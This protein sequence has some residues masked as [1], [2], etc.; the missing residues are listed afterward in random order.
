MCGT[1]GCGEHHHHHEHDHEHGH[2]HQHPHHHDER[3]VINLEQDILQRNNL[4]AERNR[5]YFEAKHIFCLNLMSSPGSGKTSLLEETVRRLKEKHPL[6]VVEGDQ[7]TSNDA[8]RIAAL[9]IPVFQVNTGTGC[10]LEADMVNH[11]VKHLAPV[12]NSILFIEN[13][14]NLVCPAMFNLGEAKKVVIVSTTEGDDKPLKYPH[15]FVEADVCIINKV[16]LAPYLDTDV[17]VLRKNI[18]NVNHHMQIFEVSATKG[19]G[20]EAWCNWLTDECTKCK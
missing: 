20:M 19:T 13:V 12:D 14:G 3:I 15:I 17:E 9:D 2:G 10:H 6:Y 1:C 7:Q 18:L 16:D 11:A 4:L 5:G 8:D